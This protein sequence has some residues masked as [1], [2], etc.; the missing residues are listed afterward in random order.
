MD[1]IEMAANMAGDWW[2]KKLAVTHA[3]KRPAFAAAVSRLVQ[4]ALRGEAHWV[5]GQG[6]KV[7]AGEPVAWVMTE[8]DYDPQGLMLDA[9]REVIDQNCRGFMFSGRGILPDKTCLLVRPT[10]L[11]PKEGYGNRTTAISVPY[12]APLEPRARDDAGAK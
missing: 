12:N 2:A 6:K 10:L 3:D 7:G 4:Q 8:N 9:V 5:W 11:E 1:Q